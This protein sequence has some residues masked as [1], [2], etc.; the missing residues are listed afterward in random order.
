[1]N[2]IE[3]DHSRQ[4]AE[5]FPQ[6][7]ISNSR[8]T[9]YTITNALLWEERH[10]L[11]DISNLI[12][13]ICVNGRILDVRIELILK[14][15]FIQSTNVPSHV[16]TIFLGLDGINGDGTNAVV[17]FKLLTTTAAEGDLLPLPSLLLFFENKYINGKVLLFFSKIELFFLTFSKILYCIFPLLQIINSVVV[18]NI[19][20]V[21]CLIFVF[22]PMEN[23]EVANNSIGRLT[24]TDS[25]P[26]KY[27]IFCVH[28]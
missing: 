21:P 11:F 4:F 22:I 14:Y 13:I 16:Y 1:M 7:N 15:V 23:S 24:V 26:E 20:H 19:R 12:R 8:L 2:S 27:P 3:I 18:D 5:F 28:A 6:M 25:T 10:K 9:L 17:T